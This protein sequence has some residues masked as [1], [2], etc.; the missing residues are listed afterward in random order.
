[1]T[2]NGGVVIDDGQEFRSPSRAAAIAADMRTVDGWHAWVDESGRSL[3]S[4][5]SELLDAVAREAITEE[6]AG[7]E[8]LAIPQRRHEYLKDARARADEGKSV[9]TTVR[10][11]LS[12][13][14]ARVRSHRISQRIDADLANHGLATSPSFRK[15]TL[16]AT[17]VLVGE[18]EELQEEPPVGARI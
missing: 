15:V 5:R 13:W 16:D 8:A 10:E 1:V 4:L 3:D 6:T 2:A 17:V 18:S 11:L 9:E 12:L 14:G 7:D